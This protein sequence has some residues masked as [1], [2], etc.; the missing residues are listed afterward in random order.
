MMNIDK[1]N[2]LNSYGEE[3]GPDAG[4]WNTS[5]QS[6]YLEYKLAEVF[7]ENFVIPDNAQICNVGIGAG[8]WDRY[9]SY[10]LHG[11]HLTSIDIDETICRNLRERLINEKNPNH[12]TII[13][14]DIIELNGYDH[15]F[16]LITLVGSTRM[17]IG[18]WEILFKK[19][20]ELMNNG[21]C[22]YYMEL[23]GEL[24]ANELTSLFEKCGFKVT[25]IINDEK[26]RLNAS[27]W[28]LDYIQNAEC[29]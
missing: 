24:S 16:D 21:G 7:E 25:N 13:C 4:V 28:R 22:I 10:R 29:E 8:Y 12:V 19:L 20:A 3:W 11:G 9:L 26:Y 5:V 18:Q 6:K 27:Y 15:Y 17:E 23:R 14:S 1:D 2:L